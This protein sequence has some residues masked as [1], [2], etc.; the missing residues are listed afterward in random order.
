M[1]ALQPAHPH[2]NPP[3]TPSLSYNHS[4]LT[5]HSPHIL[6]LPYSH[7]IPHLCPIAAPSPPRT[8]SLPYSHPI[9]TPSLPYNHSILT[10]HSPHTLFLPYSHPIPTPSLP[11]SHP[12]ATPHPM[13]AL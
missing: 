10:L 9:P 1:P 8:P 6:F 11:Y 12:I 13:P 4:I 5:L 3:H 7:L 2:P